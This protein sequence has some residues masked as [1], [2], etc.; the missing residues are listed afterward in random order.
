MNILAIQNCA[1][2][3]FGLYA[4]YFL[5]HHADLTVI[6]AYEGDSLPPLFGVDVILVGGTPVAAYDA[7]K[8]AFL[9]KV[10][11]YLGS[12]VME[13][14][15]C[16]GICFGAQIL[17]QILGAEAK[18]SEQTEIGCYEV[19]VTPEG[20]SHPLLRGFPGQFPVFQWHGDLFA[21]PTGGELLVEGDPC[22]NQMFHSEN[23]VGVTF[24]LEVAPGEIGAWSDEYSEEL[25]RF[26][27][28]RE[29]VIEECRP[30]EREMAVLAAKLMENFVEY[31]S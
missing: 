6:H 29:E 30:R 17:A 15:A 25:A 13:G 26:G 11:Q 19:R 23:V 16:F 18:K 5:D 21:V 7:Q 20:K 24:H 22:H 8:P 27:K 12:A 2:E 4:H 31:V 9:R 28:T 1:L 14:K 3:G 10:T